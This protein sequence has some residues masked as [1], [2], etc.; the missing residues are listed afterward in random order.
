[1]GLCTREACVVVHCH[2][3]LLVVAAQVCIGVVRAGAWYSRAHLSAL[4]TRRGRHLPA[5]WDRMAG[6]LWVGGA[7]RHPAR[8]AVH[9]ACDV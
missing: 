1:M 8:R 3:I 6:A 2:L 5:H 4:F 9:W 7:H